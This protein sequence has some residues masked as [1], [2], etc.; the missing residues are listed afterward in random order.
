MIM[1]VYD[2]ILDG[3]W[4]NF[5]FYFNDHVIYLLNLQPTHT[6]KSN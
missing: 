2:M 5:Q 4:R 1:E 6:F 3:P